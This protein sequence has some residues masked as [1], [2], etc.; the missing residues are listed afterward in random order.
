[1]LRDKYGKGMTASDKADLDTVLA[2]AIV[3]VGANYGD[4]VEV[5]CDLI[6][7]GNYSP[8]LK[9]NAKQ[10]TSWLRNYIQSYIELR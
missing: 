2:N 3:E 8:A 7:S 9:Y 1:M 4:V 6:M 5:A 10:K